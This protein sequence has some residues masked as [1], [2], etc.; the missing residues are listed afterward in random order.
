MLIDQVIIKQIIAENTYKDGEV[1]LG[2]FEIHIGIDEIE[3]GCLLLTSKDSLRGA[4]FD[5]ILSRFNRRVIR[6]RQFL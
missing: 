6:S 5:Q 2:H 3:D 4:A 1:D